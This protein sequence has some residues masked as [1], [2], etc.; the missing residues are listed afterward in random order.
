M[1]EINVVPTSKSRTLLT[2]LIGTGVWS[3]F[4]FGELHLWLIGVNPLVLSS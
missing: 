1:H 2:L 4:V 3:A